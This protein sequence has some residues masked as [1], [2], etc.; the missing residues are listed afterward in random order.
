MLV[1]IPVVLL[2]HHLPP[3]LLMLTLSSHVLMRFHHLSHFL[4]FLFSLLLLHPHFLFLLILSAIF[5]FISSSFPF[6][7]LFQKCFLSFSFLHSS[8]FFDLCLISFS[9]PSSSSLS[10][11]IH[12]PFLPFLEHFFFVFLLFS[13][14]PLFFFLV[15]LFGLSCFTFLC[16]P[17]FLFSY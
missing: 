15:N 6:F 17:L 14:P 7:P 1:D 2:L 9:M 10:S 13:F 8:Q 4:L 3:L 12:S 16:S 5:L 11:C